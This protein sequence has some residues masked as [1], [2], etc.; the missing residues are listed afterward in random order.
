[1]EENIDSKVVLRT[2]GLGKKVSSPEG[3]LTIL[4]DVD[5]EVRGGEIVALI[6]PSG[7]RQDDIAGITRGS[8]SA[9]RRPR[10][11]V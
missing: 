1:M 5:L 9:D 4:D 11:V 8:G 6:G 10:L 3:T 7:G 2:S